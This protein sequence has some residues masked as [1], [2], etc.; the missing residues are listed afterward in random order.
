[1]QVKAKTE[2][3]C[4]GTEGEQIGS[5]HLITE[6]TGFLYLHQIPRTPVILRQ[7][8][9]FSPPFRLS[10]PAKKSIFPVVLVVF[11]VGQEI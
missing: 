5:L 11:Q 1:M 4:G 10:N 3:F 2:S 7:F 9:I 6:R 8:S